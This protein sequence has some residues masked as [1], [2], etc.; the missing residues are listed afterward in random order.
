MQRAAPGAA[1][2][3]R[4]AYRACVWLA[5]LRHIQA[6]CALDRRFFSSAKVAK[7]VA[8]QSPTDGSQQKQRNER[9]EIS[10]NPSIGLLLFVPN[11]ACYCFATSET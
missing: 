4:A 5:M 8:T 10:D 6:D 7:M 9:L 11:I 2:I 1:Q 3:K